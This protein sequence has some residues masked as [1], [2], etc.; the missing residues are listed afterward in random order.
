[1]TNA[2]GS[3]SETAGLLS[4]GDGIF[5]RD[6]SQPITLD[7]IK[8]WVAANGNQAV[9]HQDIAYLMNSTDFICYLIARVEH[10]QRPCWRK[11]LDM[12]WKPAPIPTFFAFP[13]TE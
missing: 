1:M 11:A 8:R 3:P 6:S 12:F 13:A 10:E 5:H 9:L 2:Q 7:L 4:G